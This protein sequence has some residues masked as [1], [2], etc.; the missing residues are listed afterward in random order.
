MEWSDHAI[1]LAARK[2]GEGH[3]VLDVLSQQKGRAKGY[4]RG[5][6]SRRQRPILEVGNLVD[7]TWRGR[8][9]EHLGTFRVEMI[10]A[11]AP[12]LFRKP[13]RLAALDALTSLLTAILPEQEAVPAI[14]KECLVFFTMLGD[15]NTADT[16]WGAELV[17][18]EVMLLK[19]LGF[20]LDLT[21]CTVTGELD[22]LCYVS[23]KTGRAVSAGAGEAYKDKLLALP[24]FLAADTP[25]TAEDIRAGLLLTGHFL[26]Q[27]LLPQPSPAVM[28]ARSR[29]AGYFS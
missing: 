17:R 16:S 15:D 12:D 21:A 9:D 26:E 24:A 19:T 28:A 13:S 6:S 5:G 29:L 2:H 18:L 8:L 11:T 27:H 10:K 3:A 7:V 4:V 14:Y 22:N 25:A 1:V 20:G 23:P